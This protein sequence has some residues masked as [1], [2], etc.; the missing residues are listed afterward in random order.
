MPDLPITAK[1]TDDIEQA[2]LLATR[3]LREGSDSRMLR[4]IVDA[5]IDAI[6]AIEA[7]LP[8]QT[9]TSGD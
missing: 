2:R 4:D 8:Q 1:L 3:R 9:P 5:I 6:G 7:K